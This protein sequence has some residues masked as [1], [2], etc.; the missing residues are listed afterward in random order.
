M[1]GFGIGQSAPRV[2]DRRFLQGRGTFVDNLAFPGVAHAVF[3]RSPHGHADI[4]SVDTTAAREAPGVLLVC[5]SEEIA[6]AGLGGITSLFVPPDCE[7]R[8]PFTPPHPLL[9]AE[10]VRFVGDRV[11]MVVAES[12]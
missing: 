8:T 11:A 10:R 2:E 7:G 4:V 12:P 5:T 6:V 3:L 1:T 9:Q